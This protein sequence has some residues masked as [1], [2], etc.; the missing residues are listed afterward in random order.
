MTAVLGLGLAALGRPGYMTVGHADDLPDA[1]EAGLEARTFEV[2]DRAHAL[3]VRHFDT[4][5]SYGAAEAFLGRWLDSRKVVGVTVSSKWGYRYTAGWQRTASVHE[6]KEHGLAHLEE[7]LA[8]SRALLGDRLTVYQVHSLTPDSPILREGAVIDRL[9]RLRDEGLAIG[10]SVSGP[11]QAEL[12]EW[13]RELERGGQRVFGWVQATWNVLERSA[14][15]ALLAAHDAGMKV[16]IKEGLAN[17]RLGPRSDVPL[18]LE[19]CRELGAAPDTLALALVLAQPF[20]DVVLSGA[21]T[22]AQLESNARAL[23][24]AVDSKWAKSLIVPPERYWADRATLS[25]T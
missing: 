9:A 14:G 1:S 24:H 5:R 17:G 11:R 21:V 16:I 2:L 25:W 10:A 8:Q 15:P 3:G 7:Q 20:A 23:S 12:I 22:P 6:V 18:W 4:A 13:M 19:R